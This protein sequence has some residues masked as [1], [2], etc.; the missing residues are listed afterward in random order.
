MSL[1]REI[2]ETRYPQAPKSGDPRTPRRARNHRRRAP[3]QGPETPAGD[4][5]MRPARPAAAPRPTRRRRRAQ[6]ARPP[7]PRGPVRRGRGERFIPRGRANGG[8]DNQRRLARPSGR[9]RLGARARGAAGWCT[10]TGRGHEL[11]RR[12][13]P[14]PAQPITALCSRNSTM[15]WSWRRRRASRTLVGVMCSGAARASRLIARRRLASLSRRPRRRA[16]A[17]VVTPRTSTHTSSTY[18]PSSAHRCGSRGTSSTTAMRVVA[19]NVIRDSSCTPRFKGRRRAR[20]ASGCPGSRHRVP[21][22]HPIS[23]RTS[24]FGSPIG[25]RLDITRSGLGSRHWTRRSVPL[26]AGRRVGARRS[27]RLSRGVCVRISHTC[28]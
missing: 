4:P 14:R 27:R 21:E 24:M 3:E 22:S 18:G 15:P 23:V 6:P 17:V 2:V 1:A 5:A 13:L 20:N 25:C 26:L 8:N 16:I 10:A 19:V 12:R 9:W 7:P 11:G 28:G